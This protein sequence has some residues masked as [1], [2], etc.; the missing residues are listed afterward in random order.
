MCTEI[1]ECKLVYARYKVKFRVLLINVLR[2]R[3]KEEKGDDIHGCRKIRN[4]KLKWR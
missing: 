1:P 4:R 2:G 3:K